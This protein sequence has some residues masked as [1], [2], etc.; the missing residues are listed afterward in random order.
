MTPALLWTAAALALV[1]PLAVGMLL[2]CRGAEPMRLAAMQFAVGVGTLFLAALTF[3]LDQASSID[4][5]LTFALLGLPATLLFALF[6]E[7]W[8]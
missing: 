5:A 2:C 8:L 3:T 1:P 7:R 6:Y 4:L